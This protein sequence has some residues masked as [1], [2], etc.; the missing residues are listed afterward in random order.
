MRKNIFLICF[1][2]IILI[3]PSIFA[4]YEP[5]F[6]NTEYFY[7]PESP[8]SSCGIVAITEPGDSSSSRRVF[9]VDEEKEKLLRIVKNQIYI[10]L[11]VIGLATLNAALFAIVMDKVRN[12]KRNT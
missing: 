5:N 4:V 10:W 1:I 12:K 3:L 7:C 9:A 6:A 11:L 2:F 8:D